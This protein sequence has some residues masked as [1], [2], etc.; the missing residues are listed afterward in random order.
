MVKKLS[1]VSCCSLKRFPQTFTF[2]TQCISMRKT[3]C[4]CFFF[5]LFTFSR[6][7]NCQDKW[8]FFD[9]IFHEYLI[10]SMGKHVM[11]YIDISGP[12]K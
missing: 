3:N 10:Y 8:Y 9:M 2:V 7:E 6:H 11:T 1:C 5:V 4:L 12:H